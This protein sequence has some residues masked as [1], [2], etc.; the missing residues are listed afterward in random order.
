MSQ[1]TSRYQSQNLKAAYYRCGTRRVNDFQAR[2]NNNQKSCR[3][4]VGI[5][6]NIPIHRLTRKGCL[7]MI[8]MCRDGAVSF[9]SLYSAGSETMSYIPR[10]QNERM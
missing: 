8:L 1:N 10:G 3:A 5:S 2:P 6:D 7:E 9:L 4:P